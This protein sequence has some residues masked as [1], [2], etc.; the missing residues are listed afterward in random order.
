MKLEEKV[1]SDALIETVQ[2][3]KAKKGV[4]DFGKNVNPLKE[5]PK[6]QMRLYCIHRNCFDTEE[7]LVE[8]IEN[9][10]ISYGNVEAIDYLGNVAGCRDVIGVTDLDGTFNMYTVVN[11]DTYGQYNHKRSTYEGD[12]VWEACHGRIRYMYD[13][14]RSRGIVFTNDIYAKVDAYYKWIEENSEEVHIV[15]GRGA[16]KKKISF[17]MKNGR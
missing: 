5:I 6:P 17:M 16:R 8:Y 7:E 11:E 9:N 14:F 15:C 1:F 10:D 3:K 12:F 13:A 2:K 4:V